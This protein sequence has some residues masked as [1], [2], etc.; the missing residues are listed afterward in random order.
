[1]RW[2]GHEVRP[3]ATR[4]VPP[5]RELVLAADDRAV[6]DRRIQLAR[7][8]REQHL[9]EV[10]QAASKA[11]HV[12]VGQSVRDERRTQA[13]KGQHAPAPLAADRRV[14][15][16][17]VLPVG[18]CLAVVGARVG[19]GQRDV[20]AAAGR[21]TDGQVGRELG[22]PVHRHVAMI[23]RMAEARRDLDRG[24]QLQSDADLLA[25]PAAL[26]Q[27]GRLDRAGA[28]EDVVGVD[29]QVVCVPVGIALAASDPDDAIAAL[30]Q[31]Q[32]GALGDHL[33]AGFDRAG[34]QGARHRLL[35]R[36]PVGLIAEHAAELDGA[37]SELRGAALEHRRRRR[38]SAG[39]QRHRQLALD[40]FGVA[41]EALRGELVDLVAL[42]PL[43]GQLGRQ[44]V[45]QAAVDLGAAADAAAFGIRDTRVAERGREP[46]VAVLRVHLFERERLQRVGVDPRALL[47]DRDGPSGARQCAR[48]DG[49]AGP[50]A[51][52]EDVG[53]QRRHDDGSGTSS[54][55]AN[56]TR[57]CSKRTYW[58]T[59]SSRLVFQRSSRP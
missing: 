44:A 1:M 19:E 49:S 34:K 5:R 16:G 38:R 12:A 21:A 58:R 32:H 41:V 37:P 14:V 13:G 47:D 22:D 8:G 52:D 2:T 26:E 3:T 46:A 7:A 55:S 24:V 11:T 10:H 51:D 27:G 42:A 54:F 18:E 59:G 9:T 48:G 15:H 20:A 56:S 57:D 23:E 45:V 25:N 40:R 6:D 53:L 4:R 35:D 39:Q 50:G 36:S 17:N 31:L 29:R 28:H 33:R 43:I 30:E